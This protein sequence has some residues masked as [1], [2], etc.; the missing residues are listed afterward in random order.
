MAGKYYST[1]DRDVGPSR[2]REVNPCSRSMHR[3][4]LMYGKRVPRTGGCATRNKGPEW[5]R[6]D[7]LGT[8]ETKL[9]YKPYSRGS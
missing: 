8:L 7:V 6:S 3:S 4:V 5:S 2:L 9:L 1:L